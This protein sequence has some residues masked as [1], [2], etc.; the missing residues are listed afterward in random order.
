VQG[1]RLPNAR[2]L[3]LVLNK[4]ADNTAG[5]VPAEVAVPEHDLPLQL[6]PLAEPPPRF[7]KYGR[8]ESA[9]S[10]EL[11]LTSLS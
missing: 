11:S 3:L 8:S 10:S 6:K 7:L 2:E 1:Q 9:V 4:L 5:P